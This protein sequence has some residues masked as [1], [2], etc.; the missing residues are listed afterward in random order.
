MSKFLSKKLRIHI[1]HDTFANETYGKTIIT[2]Q[3][4]FLRYGNLSQQRDLIY[5]SAVLCR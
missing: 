2:Y 5:G 3:T 1:S 4:I